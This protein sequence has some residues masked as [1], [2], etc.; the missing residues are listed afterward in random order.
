MVFLRRFGLPLMDSHAHIKKSILIESLATQKILV[1]NTPKDEIF[2]H[3]KIVNFIGIHPWSFNEFSLEEL[4]K[5]LIENPDIHVGEIGVDK[6][7]QNT[8]SATQY[9]FFEKQMDL[10]VKYN[11][12]VSIHCV[13]DHGYLVDYFRRIGDNCPKKIMFHSFSGS[14]EISRQLLKMK[15]SD[16]FYFSFSIFVNGRYL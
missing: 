13:R 1:M 11:R 15:Q 9:V 7:V 5:R 4:E 10:A 2:K 3:E 6:L 12:K 16:R 14:A 8:C